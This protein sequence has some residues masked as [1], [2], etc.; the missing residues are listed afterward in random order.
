MSEQRLE[1]YRSELVRLRNIPSNKRTWKDLCRLLEIKNY[2]LYGDPI[3][4]AGIIITE[5][6]PIKAYPITDI[7]AENDSRKIWIN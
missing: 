7:M 5:N 2:I 6:K 1:A 4:P 3:P